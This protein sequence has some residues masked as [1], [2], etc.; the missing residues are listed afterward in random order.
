MLTQ[1]WILSNRRRAALMVSNLVV[2]VW[3]VLKLSPCPATSPLPHNACSLPTCV[4]A[5]THPCVHVGVAT[6]LLMFGF[7]T[8]TPG[9][10][11]VRNWPICVRRQPVGHYHHARVPSVLVSDCLR[12]DETGALVCGAASCCCVVQG[13]YFGSWLFRQWVG[14]TVSH[15]AGGHHRLCVTKG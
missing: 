5:L 1:S 7:I 8:S 11:R 9:A 6:C 15:R 13:V 4:R 2:V 3:A 10:S 14:L 12:E